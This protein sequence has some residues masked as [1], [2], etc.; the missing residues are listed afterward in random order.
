MFRMK[1]AWLATVVTTAM[2][3]VMLLSVSGSDAKT[4]GWGFVDGFT[5][6]AVSTAAPFT[7]SPTSVSPNAYVA[8]DVRITNSQKSNISALLMKTDIPITNPLGDPIY[9]FDATWTDATGSTVTGPARP[10]DPASGSYTS[11]P[12]SCNFGALNAGLSVTVE[13]VF[14]VPSTL[15]TYG[16]GFNFLASGNGNTPSDSGGT[17]HGDTLKGPASV[18]VS[19]NSDF[20]GGFVLADGTSFS[21]ATGDIQQT[22]VTSPANHIPVTLSESSGGTVSQCG[23]GTPIGQLVTLH[24]DKGEPFG[25][26]TSGSTFL[27]TLRIQTSALPDETELG[28][29][30]FC[31]LY[32]GD[33]T[34]LPLP[35]CAADA[36]PAGNLPCFWPKWDQLSS[37]HDKDKNGDADDADGHLFLVID[38][39]DVRNGSLR[40][41]L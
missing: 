21:T 2:L 27:T 1:I 17:S 28:Q 6:Q 20:A 37:A 12:L 11:A 23:T 16:Y 19:S 35:K 40:G 7:G 38:V 4:P 36:A 30:G 31:H 39:W 33:T 10:C 14:Q 13:I 18:T 32:D 34:D 26:P 29:V 41:Q 5:N 25:T 3:A 15:G 8:F 9:I 24:V 22:T